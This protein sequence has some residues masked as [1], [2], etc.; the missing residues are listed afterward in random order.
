MTYENIKQCNIT[1]EIVVLY[2]I[3]AK[4]NLPFPNQTVF[5]I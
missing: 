3:T 4:L 1:L 2:S 5:P